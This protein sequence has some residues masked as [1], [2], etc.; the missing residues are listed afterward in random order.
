MINFP[1]PKDPLAKVLL[2]FDFTNTLATGETL[3][4]VISV[5]VTTRSGSDSSPNAILNGANG[6]ASID[7]TGKLVYVGV[8][9]GIDGCD[10]AI[11][12]LAQSSNPLKAPVIDGVLSVRT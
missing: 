9:G 7:A 12:V 2:T 1:N 10:Y 8:Q 11:K 6:T 3:T 4:S 5:T